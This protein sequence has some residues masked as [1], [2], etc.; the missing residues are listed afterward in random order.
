MLLDEIFVPVL[1]CFNHLVSTIFGLILVFTAS[2]LWK[3]SATKI[4][5]LPGPKHY[6]FFGAALEFYSHRHDCTHWAFDNH[7]KYGK[8]GLW[9][10][11]SPGITEIHLTDPKLIAFTLEQDDP[12]VDNFDARYRSNMEFLFH[13]KNISVLKGE[14]WRARRR[15]VMNTFSNRLMKECVAPAIETISLKLLRQIDKLSIKEEYIDFQNLWRRAIMESTL[16]LLVGKKPSDLDTEQQVSVLLYELLDVVIN[17]TH[18]PFWKIKRFLRIGKERHGLQVKNEFNK[19]I[20]SL[21]P[22]RKP[23]Q[24]DKPCVINHLVTMASAMGETVDTEY[25]RNLVIDLIVSVVPSISNVG[26]WMMYYILSDKRVLDNVLQELN[27]A[28]T[29]IRDVKQEFPYLRACFWETSRL[30]NLF[31]DRRFTASEDF[32]LPNGYK[33]L[34]SQI[35]VLDRFA[36]AHDPTIWGMDAD[37]FRPERMLGQDIHK[38]TNEGKFITFRAGPRICP[39]RFMAAEHVE[40]LIRNMLMNFEFDMSTKCTYKNLSGN[41]VLSVP[42]G[43]WMKAKRLEKN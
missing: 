39:G 27:V 23:E 3:V 19:I 21:L 17:R 16:V 4:T 7:R 35:L 41:G 13:Q 37:S 28:K 43:L 15:L 40:L 14:A 10:F 30:Q 36:I 11:S 31:S 5:D 34:K 42:N 20:K 22:E 29:T 2:F 18:D 24:T 32:V 9:Y 25:A 26:S 33:I 1:P 12:P 38:L 6:P 8:N